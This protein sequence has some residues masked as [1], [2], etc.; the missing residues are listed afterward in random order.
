VDPL[1]VARG[2]RKLVDALLR[3][4]KPVAAMDLLTDLPL[5]S[6]QDYS[7]CRWPVHDAVPV[8]SGAG[9]VARAGNTPER[10]PKLCMHRK[11]ID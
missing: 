1:V 10:N 11:I 5:Q 6:V 4:G 8:V 7:C 3:N 2:L 9:S